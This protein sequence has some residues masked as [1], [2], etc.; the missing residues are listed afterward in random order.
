M[1]KTNVL[2]DT[3]M[4]ALNKYLPT[5]TV[6][7]SSDNWPW[8]TPQIKSITRRRQRE[9]IKHRRSVKWYSFKKKLVQL[10]S[11][12]KSKY[13]KNVVEDIIN[14]SEKQWY[15]K[16]KRISSYDM[17]LH[18][19]IQVTEICEYTKEEQAE[20]VFSCCSVSSEL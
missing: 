20:I 13:Y 8:V 1:K 5:K 4:E 18:E 10:V 9:Y 12:S 15:S 17:H 19:S 11:K 16:L 2:Q 3:I 7:F 14:S 6:N